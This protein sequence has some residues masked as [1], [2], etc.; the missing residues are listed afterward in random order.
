M[1][2][3]LLF[4]AVSVFS[5][6]FLEWSLNFSP[7]IKHYF[8]Y[9][10]TWEPSA[11]IERWV[12]RLK[13][14]DFWIIYKKGTENAADASSRLS[15]QSEIEKSRSVA[16]E[17]K[18]FIVETRSQLINI[19]EIRHETLMDDTLNL[20]MKALKDNSWPKNSMSFSDTKESR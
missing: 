17:Y 16:D 1:K 2:H 14:F 3:L 12:L 4:W 10:R 5:F 11:R 18:N 6:F 13:Q 8:S 15:I 7:I 19:D 9:S 20:V